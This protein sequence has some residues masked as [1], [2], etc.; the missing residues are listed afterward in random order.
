MYKLQKFQVLCDTSPCFKLI[1]LSDITDSELN[2]VMH[3]DTI[4]FKFHCSTITS[5]MMQHGT[6]C[7]FKS[8][9]K[10][11]SKIASCQLRHSKLFVV[12]FSLV[13]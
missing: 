9:K 10:C 8:P 6:L 1:S 5:T 7:K 3:Q 2:F 13:G 12:N 4:T 11:V